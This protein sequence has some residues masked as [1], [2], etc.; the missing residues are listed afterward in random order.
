MFTHQGEISRVGP[1]KFSGRI[2]AAVSTD[3]PP[4]FPLPFRRPVLAATIPAAAA[5][6]WCW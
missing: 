5:K 1:D 3:P 6:S 4:M 2:D